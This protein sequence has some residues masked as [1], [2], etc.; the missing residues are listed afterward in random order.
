MCSASDSE[1]IYF[2]IFSHFTFSNLLDEHFNEAT[3]LGGMCINYL[4]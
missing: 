2:I 1:A 3:F 4:W